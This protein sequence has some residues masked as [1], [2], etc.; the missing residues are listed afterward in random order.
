MANGGHPAT[1]PGYGGIE[2]DFPSAYWT[3]VCGK[4]V[5]FGED[6]LDLLKGALFGPDRQWLIRA[7]GKFYLF[8][9]EDLAIKL[10]GEGGSSRVVP[11]EAT[12]TED[13]RT[14]LRWV[15]LNRSLFELPPAPEFYLAVPL[16]HAG[17]MEEIAHVL[18]YRLEA[19][20]SPWWSGGGEWLEIEAEHPF[21]VENRK[22]YD[23]TA[24]DWASAVIWSV[25]R[26]DQLADVSPERYDFVCRMRRA[27]SW[28]EWLG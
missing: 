7:A 27:L 4:V 11:V 9:A 22:E 18:D 3:K 20:K 1:F 13:P 14:L 16:L 24:E 25:F 21:D 10:E 5:P 12:A 6:E 26:P 8:L 15:G 28:Q 17:L 19:D 23:Q 2:L